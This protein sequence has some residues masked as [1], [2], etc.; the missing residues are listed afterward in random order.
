MI[1]LEYFNL[2]AGCTTFEVRGLCRK[3]REWSVRYHAVNPGLVAVPNF[4]AIPQN[5]NVGMRHPSVWS[6]TVTGQVRLTPLPA[7]AVIGLP[8]YFA[9]ATRVNP[10][11][12]PA[13]VAGLVAPL[14]EITMSRA[15]RRMVP[16]RGRGRR[17]PGQLMLPDLYAPGAPGPARIMYNWLPEFLISL[18]AVYKR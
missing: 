5:P 1:A 4:A 14:A 8:G 12:Q 7:A 13:P 3:A 18:G 15:H 9:P 2:P 11:P 6:R 17:I 16:G 10:Y